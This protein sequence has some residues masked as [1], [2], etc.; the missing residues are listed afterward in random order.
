M[1][2]QNALTR[3]EQIADAANAIEPGQ[4]RGEFSQ[5]LSLLED[6]HI[7]NFMEIGTEGGCTFYAWCK[8]SEPE[9]VKISLDW[10][11]GAS[12]T[13]RFRDPLARAT[14]DARLK[15][16]ANNVVRIEA[17]SHSVKALGAVLGSL[18]GEKL[19]FLFIDGD[20][21]AEGVRQD[22]EMYSPLVKAGGLVAFHDIKECEYHIRAGCYVHEFWQKLEANKLELLSDEHVWGGIG[23]VFL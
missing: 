3:A 7:R 20:H 23:L 1:E 6:R 10:G 2:V 12:G 18:K 4:N 9:G 8:I 17:N 16:W 11:F 13:G 14:R 5:L 21:S 19:D 22:W 15:T